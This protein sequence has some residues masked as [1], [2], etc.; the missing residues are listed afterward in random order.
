MRAD[1]RCLRWTRSRPGQVADWLTSKYPLKLPNQ[2]TARHRVAHLNTTAKSQPIKMTIR[3]QVPRKSREWWLFFPIHGM[4][5]GMPISCIKRSYTITHSIRLPNL[6]WI[7]KYNKRYLCNCC[8]QE[9]EPLIPYM[10]HELWHNL[11][12]NS[13]PFRP[14]WK[15]QQTNRN[16]NNSGELRCR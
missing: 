8:K 14:S 15:W 12:E 9:A 10:A 13:P 6:I 1:Q 11:S 3:S 16:R 7:V 2:F 5:Q 4:R